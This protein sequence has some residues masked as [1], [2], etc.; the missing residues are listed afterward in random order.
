MPCSSSRT[1]SGYLTAEL[2]THLYL[3]DVR[4]GECAALTAES[5]REDCAPAFSPDGR[6]LAF[7][8]NR[9]WHGEGRRA[10]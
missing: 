6:Q 8:G 10:R 3:L 5:T 9:D 7:V 1:S 2:R 4:S